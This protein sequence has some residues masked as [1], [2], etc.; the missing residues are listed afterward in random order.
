LGILINEIATA[1]AKGF[2]A[3]AVFWWRFFAFFFY[4]LSHCASHAFEV[5]FDA[6]SWHAPRSGGRKAPRL[7]LLELPGIAAL[8]DKRRDLIKRP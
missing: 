5:G 1:E 6:T 7:S 3:S 2:F 4:G 8:H